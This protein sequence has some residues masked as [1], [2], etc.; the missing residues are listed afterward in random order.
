MVAAVAA[1]ARRWRLSP[2]AR[3]SSERG[4]VGRKRCIGRGALHRT[5][6]KQPRY[7]LSVV[8]FTLRMRQI[9]E[10]CILFHIQNSGL[11]ISCLY[12]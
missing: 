4:K 2:A 1:A 10:L 8:A 7:Y 3:F 12:S 6:L 9:A 5:G 11:E